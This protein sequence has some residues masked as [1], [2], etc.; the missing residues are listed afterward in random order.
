MA[1]KPKPLTDEH[2]AILKALKETTEPVGSKDIALIVNLDS[3]T[4]SARIKTLKS[5]GY[6]ES[7]ARCKYAITEDGKGIV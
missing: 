1:C 6:V 3:K 2:K 5:K 4:V 7:P